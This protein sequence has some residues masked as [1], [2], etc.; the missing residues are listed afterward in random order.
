MQAM[1]I[2]D[3]RDLEVWQRS[4]DLAA[5]VYTIT[6]TFPS[7][8]R[9]GLTAQVRKAVISISSNVAEGSGRATTK[10]LLNFLSTARGSLRETESLLLVSARLGYASE[11]ELQSTLELAHRVGQMLTALRSRLEK[12]STAVRANSE[13]RKPT[14]ESRQQHDSRSTIHDSRSHPAP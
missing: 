10:D 13:S 11:S 3:F 2:H 12:K 9:F 8:E 14:A 4:V 6:R 5:E 1:R 7:D